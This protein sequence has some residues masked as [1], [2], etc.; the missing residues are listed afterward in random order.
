MRIILVFFLLFQINGFSQKLEQ[1]SIKPVHPGDFIGY[2][3]LGFG[4]FVGNNTISKI[5]D[6]ESVQYQNLSFGRIGRVDLLNPLNIVVHYPDFNAVVMLDN[7]LNEIRTISFSDATNNN[8]NNIIVAGTGNASQN[9]LWIYDNMSQQLGLYS[10]LSNDFKF[11]TQPLPGAITYYET[12]FNIFRWINDQRQWFVC[13]I[14]GKIS[15]IGTVP[16]FDAIRFVSES[17]IVYTAGPDLFLFNV[18][19]GKSKQITVAEKSIKSFH[20]N[21]QIFS[22]FTADG[23]MNYKLITP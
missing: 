1:L 6:G 13:D 3:A 23:I 2:D 4:Y 12:D 8:F 14:Y 17:V 11:L 22:I 10:Y 20:Y 9:R 18:E 19:N 5:T 16:A 15:L 21:G 7:Q